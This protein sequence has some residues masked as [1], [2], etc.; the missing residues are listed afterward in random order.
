MKKVLGRMR[1]RVFVGLLLTA[2][3]L[4]V[5]MTM[6]QTPN[7]RPFLA[8]VFGDDMVLQRNVPVPVWGW[9][10]PGEKVTVVVAGKGGVED[11]REKWITAIFVRSERIPPG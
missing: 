2:V 11:T 5:T 4:P 1:R 10:K 9:T 6:A 8:S 3:T 7:T